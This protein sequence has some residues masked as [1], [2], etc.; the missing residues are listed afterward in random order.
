MKKFLKILGITVAVVVAVFV[1]LFILGCIVGP[2]EDEDSEF[3]T[4]APEAIAEYKPLFPPWGMPDESN[5]T[6]AMYYDTVEEAILHDKTLA[7]ANEENHVD[8]DMLNHVSE[9][10][11]TWEGEDYVTVYYRTE[12]ADNSKQGSVLAKCRKKDFDGNTRYAYVN[13]QY[14]IARPEDK[15][16]IHFE[17]DIGSHLTLSDAMQDLNPNYPDTRFVCGYSHNENI[18]TLEVEGQK[19]DGIIEE[20]VYGRKIYFWYFDDLKSDKAGNCLS[21]TVKRAN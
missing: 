7:Q 1:G 20:D 13:S 2:S 10:L 16:I 17:K 21:Y 11:H 19:P 8:A 12:N 18:Y 9:I 5:I 4:Y 6:D 15:Y 3:Y 14:V